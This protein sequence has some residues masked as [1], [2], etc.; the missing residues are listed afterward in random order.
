MRA[1][2]LSENGEAADGVRARHVEHDPDGAL[3]AHGNLH[4]QVALEDLARGGGFGVE[5]RRGAG[6][7]HALGNGAHFELDVEPRHLAGAHDEPVMDVPLESR[8]PR[9][10]RCKIR[11]RDRAPGKRPPRP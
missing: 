2:R 11:A 5:Q 8:A 10:S 9:P 4:E 6:H 7:L 1:S 3:L